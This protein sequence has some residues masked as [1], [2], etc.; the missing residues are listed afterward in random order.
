MATFS[1]Q[2]L[3]AFDG[4]ATDFGH[5]HLV[6]GHHNPFDGNLVVGAR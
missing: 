5:R 3:S 4:R 2:I 6:D 1:K